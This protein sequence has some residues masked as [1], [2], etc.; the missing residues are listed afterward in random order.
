MKIKSRQPLRVG[1]ELVDKDVVG[2]FAVGKDALDDGV[3]GFVQSVA[4]RRR[5]VVLA[6]LLAAIDDPKL[7][8]QR[9]DRDIRKYL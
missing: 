3:L 8:R 1:F 2:G 6:V 7:A 9:I 4:G 5:Q